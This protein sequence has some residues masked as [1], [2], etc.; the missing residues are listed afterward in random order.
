MEWSLEKSWRSQASPLH[1]YIT[2]RGNRTP[3][4]ALR[5]LESQSA[6]GAASDFIRSRLDLY[7]ILHSLRGDQAGVRI[8]RDPNSRYGVRIVFGLGSAPWRT[9]CR[10]APTSQKAKAVPAGDCQSDRTR[11][12]SAAQQGKSRQR[13]ADRLK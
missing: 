13:A 9:L 10:P 5:G 2:S 4:S 8:T 7:S 6:L 1:N 12:C 11:C 3:V